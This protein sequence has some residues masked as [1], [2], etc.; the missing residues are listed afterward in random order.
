[1][2]KQKSLHRKVVNEILPIFAEKLKRENVISDFNRK[3]FKISIFEHVPLYEFNPDLVLITFD[4]DKVLVEVA[5]PRDPKRF[6][7][8]LFYA[9]ILGHHNHISL[10]IVFVLPL[11]GSYKL[12]E[13]RF[14]IGREILETFE[15]GVAQFMISWDSSNANNYTNLKSALLDWMELRKKKNS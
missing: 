14:S 12:H 10:S 2:S 7:G 1:M 13:R 5:N 11:K 6:L 9:Q 15:K 3:R 4:G 8:E